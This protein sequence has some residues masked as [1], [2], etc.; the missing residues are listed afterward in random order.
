MHYFN[1][2]RRL[3]AR[4]TLSEIA[5]IEQKSNVDDNFTE[6]VR[7]FLMSYL[8]S[9]SDKKIKDCLQNSLGINYLHGLLGKRS[10]ILAFL[11]T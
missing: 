2:R 3:W 8:P 5:R 6:D 9:T 11:N 7:N 4:L 10:C 1:I